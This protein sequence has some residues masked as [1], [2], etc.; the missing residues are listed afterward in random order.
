MKNIT[1]KGV[2]FTVSF[3]RTSMCICYQGYHTL[4]TTTV[5]PIKRAYTLDLSSVA[6]E[7]SSW[8]KPSVTLNTIPVNIII[9]LIMRVKS[10]VTCFGCCGTL[11]TNHHWA[12]SEFNTSCKSTINVK[13]YKSVHSQCVNL[14]HLDTSHMC[15]WYPCQYTLQYSN[16]IYRPHVLINGSTL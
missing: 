11:W 7:F 9:F 4:L 5:S 12:L 2:M 1:W 15:L 6:S 13:T 16:T 8:L 14:N 10:F 3:R